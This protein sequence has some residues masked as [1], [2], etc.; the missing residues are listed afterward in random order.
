MKSFTALFV[1]LSVWS[2]VVGADTAADAKA[3]PLAEFKAELERYDF[4]LP[5]EVRQKVSALLKKMPAAARPELQPLQK[6]LEKSG[7][8]VP[9]RGLI[10]L[11]E[12]EGSQEIFAALADHEDPVVQFFANLPLA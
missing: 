8:R 4:D 1:A 9:A 7:A 3:L 5:Q 6:S 12:Q 2:S 11:L 10:G